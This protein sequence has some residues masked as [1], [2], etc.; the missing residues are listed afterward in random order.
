MEFW[1][2]LLGKDEKFFDLLEASAE[3]ASLCS[4]NLRQF[5][6]RSRTVMSTGGMEPFNA[7]R[8]KDK[9]ITQEITRELCKTF[10]T[11]LEREDIEALSNSLYK[12]PKTVQK[13]SER[14][15]IGPTN[16]L[17]SPSLAQQVQLLEDAAQVVVSMVKLLRHGT[18]LDKIVELNKRLQQIEGEADKLVIQMLSDLY[19]GTQDAKDVIFLKDVFELVER[20]VDRC[21]DAGNTVFQVVL[22]SS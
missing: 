13:I 9:N 1:K 17:N 22:K 21:R 15:L 11:P 2:R 14:L 7:S 19:Q 8:R 18:S 10:V 3:E 12:I 5:V 6:I 4:A 20:A 16:L